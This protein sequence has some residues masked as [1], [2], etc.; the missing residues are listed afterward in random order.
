MGKTVPQKPVSAKSVVSK[1]Q[2]DVSPPVFKMK[3]KKKDAVS[4]ASLSPPKAAKTPKGK[5][6]I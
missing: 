5:D 4:T 6:V 1:K 2:V 3:G